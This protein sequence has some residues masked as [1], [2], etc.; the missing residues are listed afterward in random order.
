MPTKKPIKQSELVKRLLVDKE[1]EKDKELRM[2][3]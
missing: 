3:F 2:I 1:L